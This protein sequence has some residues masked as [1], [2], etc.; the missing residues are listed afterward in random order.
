MRVWDRGRVGVLALCLL[1]LGLRG[2]GW[3]VKLTKVF[4]LTI[5][6]RFIQLT[7]TTRFVKVTGEVYQ[8]DKHD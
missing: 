5:T 6:T 2:W 4:K 8:V 3:G 7:Y 1:L